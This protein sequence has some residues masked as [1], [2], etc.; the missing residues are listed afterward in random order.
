MFLKSI[1]LAALVVGGAAA[2]GRDAR[3]A[4]EVTEAFVDQRYVF[5]DLQK[6]RQYAAGLALEKIDD[7]IRLTAGHPIDD[8]TRKPKV[9]Y[10]L[11][12]KK[13]GTNRA[14]FLYEGTIRI[15]NEPEFKRRWMVV[16]RKVD[17]R[18]RVFNFTEYD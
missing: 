16:A 6:A 11:V 5:I 9:H 3:T 14:S 13:D 8:A 7:E 2:C 17:E 10:R 12:E 1:L 18:W 15:D 4:Q